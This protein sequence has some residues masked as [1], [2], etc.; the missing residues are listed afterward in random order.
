MFWKTKRQHLDLS[1]LHIPLTKSVAVAN[2]EER[3]RAVWE[4]IGYGEL[5]CD[6]ERRCELLRELGGRTGVDFEQLRQKR[7]LSLMNAFEIQTA[8]AG[9]ADIQLHT[10]RHRLNE[11]ASLVEREIAQNREFLQPLVSSKLSHLCYPS[12]IWS[13]QFWSWLQALD[14]KT[15]TTCDPGLNYRSTP[16]LGLKRFLDGE[17][18]SSIEFEAELAGFAELLRRTRSLLFRPFRA[19]ALT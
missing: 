6:E 11:D 1:G 9:G 4:I 10:H 17:N 7:N 19:S 8:A 14:I 13:R 2:R 15:A 16:L 3:E 5:H 12:G 18:I